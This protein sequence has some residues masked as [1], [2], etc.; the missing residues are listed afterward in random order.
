V[1]ERARLHRALY[2]QNIE[3]VSSSEVGVC[4]TNP[5]TIIHELGHHFG[6]DENQLKDALAKKRAGLAG[7]EVECLRFAH[8]CSGSV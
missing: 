1:S 8:N 5:P 4:A 7:K 6:M 3:D 2:H